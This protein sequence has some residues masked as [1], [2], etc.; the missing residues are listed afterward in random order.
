MNSFF[1]LTA[2]AGLLAI[3]GQTFA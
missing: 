2:F 1:R 3:A